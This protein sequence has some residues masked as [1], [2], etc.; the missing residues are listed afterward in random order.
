MRALRLLPLLAILAAATATAA[1]PQLTSLTVRLTPQNAIG[2]GCPMK[3][4]VTGQPTIAYSTAGAEN[5]VF[6]FDDPLP[7]DAVLSHLQVTMAILGTC[8]DSHSLQVRLNANLPGRDPAWGAFSAAKPTS[9]LTS[10]STPASFRQVTVYSTSV[11]PPVVRPYLRGAPNELNVEELADGSCGDVLIEYLD[12]TLYFYAGLPRV[13]F[14]VTPATPEEQRRVLMHRYRSDYD[15][16]SPWQA[17]IPGAN[18]SARDNRVMIRGTVTNPDGSAY[19]NESVYLRVMDP[20][21]APA[22]YMP[23]GEVKRF[24]NPYGWS[25]FPNSQLDYLTLWQTFTT[26]GSGRFEAVLPTA[27]FLAGD[28]QL[29]EASA[30]PLP[31]YLY[32]TPQGECRESDGCYQSGTFTAW[33]RVYL[34]ADRMF[35]EG[36]FI[37][38]DV[39][40]GSTEVPVDNARPWRQ[41]RPNNPIPITLIHAPVPGVSGASMEQ[42]NVIRARGGRRG[43]LE[44]DAPLANA[45]VARAS[46]TDSREQAGD[47]VGRTDRGTFA[48][49]TALA[50]GFFETAFTDYEILPEGTKNAVPYLPL[51]EECPSMMYC[52]EIAGIWFESSDGYSAAKNH[53]HLVAGAVNND[54]EIGH[55]V[56]GQ[57]GGFPNAAFVWNA[58]IEEIVA[59]SNNAQYGGLN[60][61]SVIAETTVHE[62]VHL[63]D[64]NPPALVSD[65]PA[66][67][68]IT[69]GHCNFMAWDGGHCL[70]NNNRTRTER[71]DGAVSAHVQPGVVSGQAGMTFP[72]GDSEYRR[73]RYRLDPLP[74]FF[75]TNRDSH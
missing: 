16:P 15:Y 72:F 17:M 58:K 18:D 29:V 13:E 26:D 66:T 60:L 35:R 5:F 33:R 21:G 42:R 40:A 71:G 10:C 19:A 4:A 47:A 46:S 64:V 54:S 67:M 23:A 41:A 37:R 14:E 1:P 57:H 39:P 9:H 50:I 53:Q 59:D 73:I 52:S 30:L 31:L 44:L 62:L 74:Q 27:W 2:T 8:P 28:N 56:M 51:V 63:Y 11:I 6:P 34:E 49:Q 55:A 32:T 3:S 45:Y 61:T 25:L 70:M 65:T 48:L 43:V 20:P 69:G 22:P 75:Q 7:P 12:V 68:P 24:D 38:T 36:A